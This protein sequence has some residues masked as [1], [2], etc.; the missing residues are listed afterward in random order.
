MVRSSTKPM[1][2]TF[3]PDISV[4]AVSK[5]GE[6][7]RAFCWQKQRRAVGGVRLWDGGKPGL[8]SVPLDRSYVLSLAVKSHH[9]TPFSRTQVQLENAA[10]PFVVSKSYPLSGSVEAGCS[11]VRA[12]PVVV[13]TVPPAPHSCSWWCVVIVFLSFDDFWFLSPAAGP[14]RI[15]KPRAP[16]LRH[17]QA[18]TTAPAMLILRLSCGGF[19][20]GG[21]VSGRG[22]YRLISQKERRT[23]VCSTNFGGLVKLSDAESQRQHVRN[24]ILADGAMHCTANSRCCS[25]ITSC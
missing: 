21:M 7:G 8:R 6:E 9:F 1:P 22:L 19:S 13:R 3:Q 4:L 20:M 18:P 12:L 25:P 10:G 5:R 24:P 23:K 17:A 14:R 15:T 2:S 16:E 11:R